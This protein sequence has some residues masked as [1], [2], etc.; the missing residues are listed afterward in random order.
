MLKI[1][2][3]LLKIEKV[4]EDFYKFVNRVNNISKKW[5]NWWKLFKFTDNEKISFWSIFI[6]FFWNCKDIY[7]FG[8]VYVCNKKLEAKFCE[9]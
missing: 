1:N 7:I 5:L 3:E 6:N 2:P 9:R 4:V 8:R